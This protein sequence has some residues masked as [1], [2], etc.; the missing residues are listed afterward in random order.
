MKRRLCL[1]YVKNEDVISRDERNDVVSGTSTCTT[2]GCACGCIYQGKP[3][4]SSTAVNGAA[5]AA[6]TWPIP[7]QSP[8][9]NYGNADVQIEF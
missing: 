8:G 4:G 9:Y 5:N 2:G 6:G 7:K 1:M 3:G